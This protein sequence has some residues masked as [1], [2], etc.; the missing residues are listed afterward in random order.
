MQQALKRASS[1]PTRVPETTQLG[2]FP[3]KTQSQQ[4]SIEIPATIAS[5]FTRSSTEES[6][7]NAGRSVNTNGTSREPLLFMNNSSSSNAPTE[8][9]QTPEDDYK[10]N[11]SQ[12]LPK[13][14]GVI[15]LSAQNIGWL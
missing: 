2:S 6:V 12:S 9:T 15:P 13:L 10:T 5:T 14:P 7:T 11:T 1:V 3:E 4:E 8:S